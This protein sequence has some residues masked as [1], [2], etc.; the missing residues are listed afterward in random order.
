MSAPAGWY[1]DPQPP[2]PGSPPQQRYW[3]GQAWTAHVA[4]T[5][6]A[7]YPA[8]EQQ[9]AYAS[10]PASSG[11]AVYA[12]PRRPTTPDGVPLAGW[13]HRV[14]ATLID[15]LILSV[16][17]G[18]LTFPFIRDIVSSFGDYF[19]TAMTAA[20]EG[21]PTPSTSAF[22]REVS[23]SIVAIGA[24]GFVVGLAYTFGFL[25]WKQATPGKLALGLRIR[26]RESPELP[27]SAI[28]LRWATQSGV[29]GL[30]GLVPL[31]GFLA[32]IFSLLNVLWPL[33]DDKN[34]AIHD[35]VAKTNVV[36]T[37]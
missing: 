1:P 25:L 37:R 12:T 32:S 17:V 27:F 15:Y 7:S 2:A 11:D 35:K 3:D 29:P 33:W 14:G 22:E 5:E 31:V 10:Y 24:V 23:G 18:A 4:P 13:W 19:D 16:V 9:P 20:E 34:Q 28:I 6:Q 8:A 26:L 30:L 36:R 21:R